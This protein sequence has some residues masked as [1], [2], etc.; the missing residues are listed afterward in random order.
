[1]KEKQQKRLLKRVIKRVSQIH[2]Q[3]TL[4]RHDRSSEEKE[5]LPQAQSFENWFLETIVTP[6]GSRLYTQLNLIIDELEVE[7]A[8]IKSLIDSFV[9]QQTMVSKKRKFACLDEPTPVPSALPSKKR[10]LIP[11]ELADEHD[12]IEINP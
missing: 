6:Y 12:M 3:M 7:N 2:L 4:E 9:K 5:Q 11:V 1:M 8:Q 10:Q